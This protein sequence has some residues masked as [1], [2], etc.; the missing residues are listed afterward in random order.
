MLLD[1]SGDYLLLEASHFSIN[2]LLPIPHHLKFVSGL[3]A[4]VYPSIRTI[5]RLHGNITWISP[6]IRRFWRVLHRY[7]S[8]V[9][10][11]YTLHI[12]CALRQLSKPLFEEKYHT[13]R[14]FYPKYSIFYWSIQMKRIGAYDFVRISKKTIGVKLIYQKFSKRHRSFFNPAF[15]PRP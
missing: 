12:E 11:R 15:K 6:H 5:N 2:C 3:F 7:T 1:Q 8:C 9:R 10:P 4:Y 13:R 14:I